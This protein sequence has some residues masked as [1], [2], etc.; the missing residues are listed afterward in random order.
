MSFE[1]Y[2]K[3]AIFDYD[4]VNCLSEAKIIHCDKFQ[5]IEY[6]NTKTHLVRYLDKSKV[7]QGYKRD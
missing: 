7:I 5:A 2:E 1:L 6:I 3:G 4:G